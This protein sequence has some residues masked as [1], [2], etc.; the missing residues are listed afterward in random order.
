MS[1]SRT[2]KVTRV[3]LTPHRNKAHDLYCSIFSH[4]FSLASPWYFFY[5][6]LPRGF[7]HHALLG[8]A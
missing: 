4:V 1:H 3:P 2:R 5:F 6:P 7:T 8:L